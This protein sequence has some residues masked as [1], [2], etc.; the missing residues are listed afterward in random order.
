MLNY[1]YCEHR[2][3]KHF[4]LEIFFFKLLFDGS[5]VEK[6]ESFEHNARVIPRRNEVLLCRRNRGDRMKRVRLLI[7]GSSYRV[8]VGGILKQAFD[9]KMRIFRCGK[10][11]V[12]TS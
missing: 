7:S 5:R 8:F 6:L 1:S 2:W 10:A 11:T 12:I 9:L 4:L 3:K